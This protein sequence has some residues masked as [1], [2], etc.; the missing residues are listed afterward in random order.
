M[1]AGWYLQPGL[2]AERGF[3]VQGGTARCDRAAFV[4]LIT[5]PSLISK[6]SPGAETDQ[7]CFH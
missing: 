5:L 7:V 1:G 6:Q 4:Q 2:D 3:S